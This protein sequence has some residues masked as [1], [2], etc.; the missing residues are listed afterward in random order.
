MGTIKQIGKALRLFELRRT[1]W[2]FV[3]R[4]LCDYRPSTAGDFLSQDGQDAFVA[5]LFDG[6]RGGVFVEIG[7]NDGVSFSNTCYLER[8]LGW[9][10]VLV[11]PQADK[12]AE[13]RRQRTAHAVN[14][15]AADHDG[16][17]RFAHVEGDANMLSGVVDLYSKKHRRRVE[18]MIAKTG[19]T[20][21]EVEVPAVRIERVLDEAGVTHIDYLSIDTEGGELDI[22]AA[23]D[24][25]KH[26]VACVGMEN[27]HRSF[28]PRRVMRSHGYEL[29]A[30]VGADEMFVRREWITGAD[31][32]AKAA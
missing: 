27:N 2:N 30:I 16:V 24:L 8:R 15:C 20:L 9:T 4:G 7:A 22:L 10:G 12:F 26:T 31:V 29:A 1:Y 17:L 32:A 19:G 6:M 3:N 18:K 21:R 14:A 28:E 5:E 25:A 13:L 23:I 11:E